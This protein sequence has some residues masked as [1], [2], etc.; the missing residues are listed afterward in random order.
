MEPLFHASLMDPKL[1]E[2][3]LLSTAYLGP[4]EY[5]HIL[6]HCPKISI[7]TQETFSK[8][9]YRNRCN[10]YGANGLQ[11]LTIPVKAANNTITKDV[12]I[13][14]SM[15]WQKQHWKSIASAYGSSPFFM[16]YDYELIP[17]FE[18]NKKFL[19][20]FNDALQSKILKFLKANI[21]ISYTDE[22]ENQKPMHFD[23][24]NRIHPKKEP[25]IRTE[26]YP[27]VFEEKFGFIPN[28]SIIDLV[29]NQG[30]EAKK[31]LKSFPESA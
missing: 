27:Q 23:F 21:L 28:L 4:L 7:E 18:G 24:R 9:S 20:D 12:Q 8:Q 3:P 6:L 2:F 29:F 5:F 16:Y 30:P 19:I 11:T 25:I 15:P 1:N 22:Y 10:I 14:Y 17:F 31:I 13:D 26:A